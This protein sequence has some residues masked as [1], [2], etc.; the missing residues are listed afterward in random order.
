VSERSTRYETAVATFIGVLALVVSAYTAYVQR[1]QVRAQVLPILQFGSSNT[2][3]LMVGIDNKGVGPAL[4]KNVV[5]TVDGEAKPDWRS[6]METLM[7]P[8]KHPFMENDIHSL[9]LAPNETVIAVTPH[10]DAGEPLHVGP[11]GSPGA[12]FNAGRLH[13]GV[14]ICYCSTLGDCWML[15]AKGVGDE[16]RTEVRRCPASSERTF[17]E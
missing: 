4:I 5:V 16:T 1:Q 2:P 13:I 8:G 9:I 3:H 15:R 14:E 6:V 7:G 12:L 17:R 11:P 10:D